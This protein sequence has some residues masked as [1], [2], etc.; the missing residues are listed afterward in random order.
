MKE[1]C[2]FCCDVKTQLS[3][4]QFIQPMGESIREGNGVSIK[5]ICTGIEERIIYKR[6]NVY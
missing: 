1:Y 2:L 4:D 6:N 5:G 3:E